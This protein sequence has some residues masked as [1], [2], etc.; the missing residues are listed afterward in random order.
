MIPVMG[1]PRLWYLCIL[2]LAAAAWGVGLLAPGRAQAQN[3][4][5]HWETP[6]VSPLALTPSGNTLLA[7]NTPDNRLEVLDVSGPYAWSPRRVRSIPVGLDPVSVRC[8]SETEAWVVNQISDSISIIDLPSGRVLRTLPTGDEP[9]DVIFSSAG[10]TARAF[11]TCSNRDQVRVYNVA[12]LAAAPT[13]VPLQGVDPRVLASSA[14]G[15]KIYVAIFASGNATTS[16]THQVVSN[17]T[18]PYGGVNPPP[19]TG[20]VFT[21]PLNPANASNP[22]PVVGIIVKRNAS[23]QWMDDN[24]RNWSPFVTWNLADNDVAIIDAATL[25][26][27]YAKGMLSTVMALGVRP[28][29]VVSLVGLDAQNEIR[30]EPRTQSKFVRVS[31]GA[32]SPAAPATTTLVDLNPHLLYN[33]PTLPQAVR[34]LSVGDPRAVL[35]HP[36]SGRAYVAGMGSNNVIVTDAAGTRHGLIEVGAGPTGLALSP[37]GARLYALSKFASSVSVIDTATNAEMSRVSLY[38]P[39]PAAIRNGRPLLYDTHRTSGTGHVSCAS[40]HLDGKS[41]FLGWDLGDPA[42]TMK[43]FNQQCFQ[44]VFCFSWHPM[45]GPMVT[46]TLQGIVGAEPLHWRGDR[47]NLA[48]FAPA[49]VGLQGLPAEPTAAEMQQFTDFVATIRFPPNSYRNIDDTFPPTLPTAGGSTGRPANGSNIFTL[50]QTL[51]SFRCVTCHTL[52]IGSNRQINEPFVAGIPQLMKMVQLRG[53]ERKRG[54]DKTSQQSIRGFGFNHDSEHDTLDTLLRHPNFNFGGPDVVTQNRHDV[55]AFLLSLSTD[56]H[57]SIGQQITFD[58]TN[59]NDPA[60]MAR[61]DSFVAF[62]SFGFRASLIAKGRQ[63]GKD[64][65][66]FYTSGGMMQSDRAGQSIAAN[67]LRNAA[68]PGSEI[69]FTVV[70]FNAQQRMGGDRDGDGVF[71]GDE[72]ASCCNPADPTSFPGSR[73]CLDVDGNLIVNVA[74][75]F[76]FLTRWFA[77]DPRADYDGLNGVTVQDIFAYLSAWFLGC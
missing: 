43:A 76:A 67:T 31:M 54:F 46:Q 16:L 14:D 75:I 4:F 25:G 8:R 69:T 19:N 60:A 42:G 61:L 2:P 49:F 55:E 40:C 47:E 20:L 11:V 22:P 24:N 23:G 33:T 65:G 13:I 34:D 37:T 18:G 26:V 7:V 45:K 32:F 56:T 68:A 36:T 53:L 21:P 73:G 50:Q 44:S 70:P 62:A 74:D 57:P 71:D 3:A 51:V 38:D 17:P 28:D 58:G 64:R 5:V 6:H 15:S 39:T 52:P 9:A 30:F 10:G 35:W 27:T 41:D 63:A 48:A 29:G 66:W 1:G 72:A 77:T 59:N 12:N